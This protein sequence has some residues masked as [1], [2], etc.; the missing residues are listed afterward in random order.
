MKKM[1]SPC[2]P[3]TCTGFESVAALQ[4][5]PLPWFAIRV[6]S[7]YEHVVSTLFRC[8]GYEEFLPRY[9]SWRRWSDRAKEVELPLF[10]GYVFCRFDPERRRPIVS[11]P[12]V[13][14]VLGIGRIPVP[15]HESE[16]EALQTVI[17]SGLPALPSPFLKVGQA[18][19]V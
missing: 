18:V 13:V 5:G 7:N 8:K 15:V 3:H 10:P 9:K 17:R 6:R 11:T 14:S 4:T 1:T 12:G 2:G 16:I 19:C